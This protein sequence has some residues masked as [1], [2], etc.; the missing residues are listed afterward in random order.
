MNPSQRQ[1]AA[2]PGEPGRSGP[3]QGP[4]ARPPVAFNLFGSLTLSFWE[5]I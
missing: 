3:T 4:L 5:E 2:N 1:M